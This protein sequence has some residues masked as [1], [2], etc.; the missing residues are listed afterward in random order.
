MRKEMEFETGP[1]GLGELQV[2]EDGMLQLVNAAGI[3]YPVPPE[4]VLTPLPELKPGDHLSNVYFRMNT[5]E[6]VLYD[7]RPYGDPADQDWYI[8]RY[9]RAP[10]K[11]G[12]EPDHYLKD[13]R[14]VNWVDEQGRNQSF[15][16]PACEQFNVML[17][18][19]NGKFKGCELKVHLGYF[20]FE[21]A[22]EGGTRFKGKGRIGTFTDVLMTLAGF[23]WTNDTI[24]FSANIVPQIDSILQARAEDQAFRVRIKKG[25]VKEAQAIEEGYLD[26]LLSLENK[27][28]DTPEETEKF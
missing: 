9:K 2:M 6:D 3:I 12:E 7:L 25:W 8:V 5:D 16:D 20:F 11:D 22:Q 23:D 19:I 26:Y 13:G 15:Y 21:D 18:V 4:K 10:H 27:P 1:K 28:E 14:K 24:P 17:E